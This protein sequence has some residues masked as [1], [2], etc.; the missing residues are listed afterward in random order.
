MAALI[1]EDSAAS[2]SRTSLGAA[3]PVRSVPIPCVSGPI[4]A[5]LLVQPLIP[6]TEGAR[7]LQAAAPTEL[8]RGETTRGQSPLGSHDTGAG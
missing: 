2:L 6:A 3:R 5:C 1:S 8:A 7:E 4:L